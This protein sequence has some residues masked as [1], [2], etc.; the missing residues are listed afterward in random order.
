MMGC[1]T[2]QNRHSIPERGADRMRPR[3]F[4]CKRSLAGQVSGSA[5]PVYR[6]C[7]RAAAATAFKGDIVVAHDLTVL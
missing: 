6:P 3:S 4:S 1:E 7:S 5:W 2:P